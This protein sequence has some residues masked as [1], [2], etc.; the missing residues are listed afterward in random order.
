MSQLPDRLQEIVEDFSYCVGREKLEYLLQL[1][2]SL[3]PLPE[4]LHDKRAEMDQVHE[5]M[6]PVFLHA[7]EKDG[8]LYYY[9][10]VPPESPTVRG[11]AAI[12][13]E[14]ISGSTAAEV[15]QIPDDFL[16]QTGLQKVL[17]ARRTN[18]MLAMLSHVKK[19]AAAH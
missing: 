16:Y 9:F 1:S 11:F 3:P 7:Q 14:G 19:L 15:A 4:W 17:S 18:G 13:Q 5:C 2:E 6:T 12:L 8:Q 10:D